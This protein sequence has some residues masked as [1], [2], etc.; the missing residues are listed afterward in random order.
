M[1]GSN[2]AEGCFASFGEWVFCLAGGDGIKFYTEVLL[3]SR[4]VFGY[5]L[6][7]STVYLVPHEYFLS[8]TSSFTVVLLF[9]TY[10]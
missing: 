1:D 9:A 6:L 3:F 2:W 7:P 4:F 10:S 5:N 8:I